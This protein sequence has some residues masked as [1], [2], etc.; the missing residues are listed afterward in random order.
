MARKENELEYNTHAAR[1]IP[2]K[3]DPY[4]LPRFFRAIYEGSK[5]MPAIYDLWNW[6]KTRG[7]YEAYDS[8]VEQLIPNDS[9]EITPYPDQELAAIVFDRTGLPPADFLKL[10]IPARLPFISRSLDGE[11]PSRNKNKGR[12]QKTSINARMLEAIQQNEDAIGWNSTQW[13]KHLKCAKSTVVE[14]DAWKQFEITREKARAERALER[15]GRNL[16]EQRRRRY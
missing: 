15:H 11:S 2:E 3:P 6:Y 8:L 9:E 7:V 10:D 12:R 1:V 14:T 4:G 16:S 5:S 13:A